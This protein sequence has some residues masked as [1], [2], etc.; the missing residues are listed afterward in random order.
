MTEPDDVTL[1]LVGAIATVEGVEPH[2]LDYSLHDYVAT[3]AVREMARTDTDDWELTFEVPDH[4]VTV[5]GTG[6][7]QIDGV[8]VRES[9]AV[10][11][12]EI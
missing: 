8:T 5:D 1:E 10:Q 12:D 2:E 9:D 11:S 3:D 6:E 7:I 4:T